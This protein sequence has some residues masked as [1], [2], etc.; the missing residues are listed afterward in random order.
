MNRYAPGPIAKYVASVTIG[1]K[2]M[3]Y[4]FTLDAKR[5]GSVKNWISIS[6]NTI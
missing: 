2:L 5:I 4:R 1:K 3:I 6:G